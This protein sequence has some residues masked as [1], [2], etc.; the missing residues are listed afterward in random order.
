M[1]HI[2]LDIETTPPEKAGIFERI[3]AEIRPPANYKKQ[4]TIEKWLAEE[5]EAAATEQF[6]KLALDGLYGQIVCIGFA[7]DDQPVKTI[8]A[9][10]CHENE[11][12]ARAFAEIDAL[13]LNPATGHND[14]LQ[15]VGHNIEFDI[16][17]LYQR[18]VRYGIRIPRSLRETFKP[19]QSQYATVDTMKI[20]SGYRGYVKLKDLA[21]EMLGDA[22]DDIDGKDVAATWAINPDEVERHCALDVNRVRRLHGMMMAILMTTALT[23]EDI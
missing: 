11:L 10:G 23:N 7:V 21:R 5:G 22:G 15:I 13:S 8:T 19:G 2:Y 9:N 6:N 4:E 17:F 1:K 20:W 18:A 12:I 16:R 3:K 14:I